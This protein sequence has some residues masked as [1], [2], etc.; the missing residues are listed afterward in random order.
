MSTQRRMKTRGVEVCLERGANMKDPNRTLKQHP[1]HFKR[2]KFF[3][4][5]TSKKTE[6]EHQQP[7]SEN[8]TKLVICG[9]KQQH[10]K[11][12]EG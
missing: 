9:K 3:S 2:K 1:F 5:Q 10:K 6:E 11:M 12:K 7:S 4:A 8:S